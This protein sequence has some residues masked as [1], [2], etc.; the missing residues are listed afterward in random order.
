VGFEDLSPELQEKARACKSK[1]ELVE[2]AASVGV[3]LSDAEL[4]AVAGGDIC[5]KDCPWDG[6]IC[7]VDTNCI[8]KAAA[9]RKPAA[10][11]KSARTSSRASRRTARTSPIP[12]FGMHDSCDRRMSRW[13]LAPL[14]HS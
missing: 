5:K 11:R 13:G 4:E 8:T 1:D 14:T 2:L 12:R 3:Y 10:Q 7:R 9:R 6:A